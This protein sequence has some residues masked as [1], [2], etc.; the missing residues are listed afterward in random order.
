MRSPLFRINCDVSL[1]SLDSSKSSFSE[2]SCVVCSGCVWIGTRPRSPNSPRSDSSSS[3]IALDVCSGYGQIRIRNQPSTI[4]IGVPSAKTSKK[5]EVLSG[6]IVRAIVEKTNAD[7]PRPE[8]TL[9]VA[10]DLW[11][12]V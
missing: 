5:S 4:G 3:E 11:I 6:N 10:V 1:G 9:P 8:I 12:Q 7:N 2:V